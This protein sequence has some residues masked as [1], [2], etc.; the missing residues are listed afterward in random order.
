MRVHSIC[1]VLVLVE[2]EKKIQVARVAYTYV[3]FECIYCTHVLRL[4]I[5]VTI[6]TEGY[7]FAHFTNPYL[8]FLWFLVQGKQN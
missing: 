8:N 6:L 4:N 1:C 7:K 5:A 3:N 2:K